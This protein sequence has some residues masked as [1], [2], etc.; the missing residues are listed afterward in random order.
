MSLFAAFMGGSRGSSNAE[1]GLLYVYAK[2]R[3][4]SA[5][6]FLKHQLY[7]SSLVTIYSYQHVHTV[8]VRVHK[9]RVVSECASPLYTRIT[10]IKHGVRHIDI[11]FKFVEYI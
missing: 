2:Q 8:H 3:Y 6:Q 11:A 5:C 9:L 1:G 4:N 7:T 10:W